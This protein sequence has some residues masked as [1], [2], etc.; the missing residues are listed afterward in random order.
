MAC[1]FVKGPGG[2]IRGRR[3]AAGAPKHRAEVAGRPES[4]PASGLPD[5]KSFIREQPSGLRDAAITHE[6]VRRRSGA[7]PEE[8]SEV[9]WAHVDDGAELGEAKCPLQVVVDVRGD[10]P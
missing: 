9:V 5:R 7:L 1:G 10:A 2:P 4:H 8:P 6:P 3:G